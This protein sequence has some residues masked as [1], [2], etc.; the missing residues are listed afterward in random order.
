MQARKLQESVQPKKGRKQQA[1]RK[2][3]AN[4]KASKK[5]ARTFARKQ[6]SKFQGFM[7]LR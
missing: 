7:H 4:R 2:M 3:H 5:I 1:N 6:G